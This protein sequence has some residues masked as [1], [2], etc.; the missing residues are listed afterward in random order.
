MSQQPLKLAHSY[1]RS[2]VTGRYD[3]IIIGS[4]LGGLST[5]SIL[6]QAGR[7]VL[8]LEQHG[9][10][11]G[12]TQTFTRKG[13][14]WD[15]GVHYVGE[16]NKK[17]SILRDGFDYVS[18]GQLQWAEMEDVYD[19]VIIGDKKYPFRK[20][21]ENLRA[22][23][24]K[25]FPGEEKGID[26]YFKLVSQAAAASKTF[27]T[28]R[29]LPRWLGSIMGYFTRRKFLKLSDRTTLDVLRS[30]TSN[31]ELIAVLAGQYGDYGMPPGE[32]SFGMHAILVRHYFEGGNYPVGGASMFAKTIGKVILDNGGTMF[33]RASVKE[34]IVKNNK[35]IGV[36][37]DDGRSIYAGTIVSNAGALNT[38]K[39]LIPKPSYDQHQLDKELK[40]LDSSTAHVC[41]YIGIKESPE[42]LKLPTGNLWL[43]PHNDHDRAITEFRQ[44]IAAPLPVVYISFP[45]AKDPVWSEHFPGRSTVEIIAPMPYEMFAKW[46]D[47]RWQKRGDEYEVLKEQLTERLLNYLYEQRPQLRGKI[48]YTELSTPLSTKHFTRYEKGELYGLNHGPNRFRMDFLRASTPIKNFYLCGQDI[49]TVGLGGALFSAV[50]TST[51]ILKRD[52]IGRIKKK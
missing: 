47:D 19:T 24:K 31:K 39:N 15:V 21:K 44:D 2:E 17:Y 16:V 32:S 34:I 20:G 3:A 25:W 49:L 23:L 30:V 43:Y 14:E 11:G 42:A 46:Q 37:M 45:S 28:D 50:I 40:Q 35:A 36:L 51:A 10:I 12:F 18:Q 1:N 26:K 33:I 38:Y 9:T 13:Y 7:R 6:A 8:V 4:G 41:L 27:Y 5:A 52:I 22:D 48:D 29:A